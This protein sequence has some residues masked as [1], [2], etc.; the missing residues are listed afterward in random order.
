LVGFVLSSIGMLASPRSALA[1]PRGGSDNSAHVLAF[2]ADEG[3][4]EQADALSGALRTRVRLQPG[5]TLGDGT[6]SLSMMAAALKC[7]NKNDAPCLQRVGDQLK[8]DRFFWGVV[9]NAPNKQLNA[10]VHLWQRGKPDSI[11]RE[12][13]ADN[14]KTPNDETLQGIAARIFEKLSTASVAPVMGATG[15]IAIHVGADVTGEVFIDGKQVGHVEKGEGRVEIMPGTYVFELRARGFIPSRQTVTVV[16]GGETGATLAMVAEA[17]PLEAKSG[18]SSRKILGW[19]LVGVGVVAVV[20]AVIEAA[21]WSSLQSSVDE[22]KQGKDGR[23][24]YDVAGV[25]VTD[26]CEHDT[27]AAQSA[28]DT[29]S[30]AK[31]TSAIAWVAGGVGVAAIGVGAFIL[32]KDMS[33]KSA[34]VATQGSLKPRV[35]PYAG[36]KAGG[37][38]LRWSF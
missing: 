8:S 3:A 22:D 26:P 11:V 30:S 5:W 24:N 37:V 10:D 25:G 28:C 14:L 7:S 35:L 38:G 21:Q 16:A 27:P 19:S 20:V 17:P 29:N 36:P 1:Q 33:G 12:T 2:E 6:N 4:E 32:V 31:T 23:G 15:A 34:P 18:A 9:S 13:F